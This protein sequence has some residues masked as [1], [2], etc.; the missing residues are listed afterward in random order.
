MPYELS[1][2]R[3]INAPRK[4]VFEAW[5]DPEKLA[6]FMIPGPGMS[7]PK[8]ESDAKV[9]GEFLIVMKA[10]DMELPHRGE[11][12]TIDKYET[13]AF[14][15]LSKH[16]PEG[17]IVTL[18]FKELADEQTELTLKHTGLPSVE[19]HNNHEEGWGRILQVLAEAV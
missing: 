16:A 8:A 2:T 4:T 5:L 12:K 6:K 17:S 11:Y 18:N 9:G 13:L 14:S 3:V 10:G 19:S 1:I 15:W 7:V